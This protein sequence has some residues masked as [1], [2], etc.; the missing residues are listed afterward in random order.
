MGI[1]VFA[2]PSFLD[3]CTACL[4]YT[5]LIL[6]A[7]S[8]Y[9]M[10]KGFLVIVVSIYSI[11]FLKL[12]LFRH[13]VVGVV[14]ILIGVIIVGSISITNV[15]PSAKNPGLGI[16]LLIIAQLFA[17]GNFVTEQ[18]YLKDIKVHPLQVVGI[19]GLAGMVYFL[20]LLPLL[21]LIPCEHPDLF[22]GGSVENSIEALRQI[23]NS[24]VIFL[25]VLGFMFGITFYYFTGVTV[26]KKA[27]ALARSTVETCRALIIWIISIL[28]GWEIFIP[29][30]LV[31]FCFIVAGTAINN[32][33]LK[34]SY[35][36]L[37]KSIEDRREY[38]EIRKVSK[39]NNE[40]SDND[41]IQGLHRNGNYP[42]I[43][44]G[45]FQSRVSVE[46]K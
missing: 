13:Q 20:V 40:T 42:G 27:G 10:M 32:E 15:A 25:C 30:Q 31:G 33:V 17:G 39:H 12:K 41:A 7:P 1:F 21:N 6:I 18:L 35:F 37:K 19:E 24:L 28:I 43:A 44:C 38:M 2:I 5:G 26:T 34:I 9:Q 14:L 46:I 22:N 36:G 16:V 29:P 8:V 11:V 3:L 23:E 45:A 4:L